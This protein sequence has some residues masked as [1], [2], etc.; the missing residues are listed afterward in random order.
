MFEDLRKRG[1]REVGYVVVGRPSGSEGSDAEGVS[2]GGVAW[3]ALFGDRGEGIWVL[4]V[5]S[6]RLQP[7]FVT[8]REKITQHFG[9]D[10]C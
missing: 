5:T 6:L 1:L 4:L 7:H 2:E 3:K 9:L 8:S 10:F